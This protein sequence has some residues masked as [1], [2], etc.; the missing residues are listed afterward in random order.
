VLQTI[1]AVEEYKQVYLAG[2]PSLAVERAPI[3]SRWEAPV[4]GW[5]KANWDAALDKRTGQMAFG[6]IVRDHNG[7]VKVMRSILARGFLSPFATEAK[8]VLVAIQL[9]VE[10]GFPIV[11]LEGDAKDV[12][13]AVLSREKNNGQYGHVME[14]IQDGVRIFSDWKIGHIRHERNGVAHALA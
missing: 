14:D 12:V 11:Y 3:E 9:C 1:W 7:N 10:M 8:A 4:Y 2:N 5:V 6:V 13:D